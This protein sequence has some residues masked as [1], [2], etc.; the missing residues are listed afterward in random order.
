MSWVN[1]PLAGLLLLV[2]GLAMMGGGAWIGVDNLRFLEADPEIPSILG[3]LAELRRP[4]GQRPAHG[5]DAIALLRN[6]IAHGFTPK[7][8]GRPNEPE[9][10]GVISD[11]YRLAS[12][13]AALGILW[14][15][16]YSG[17]IGPLTDRDGSGR[18][19]WAH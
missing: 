13:Y 2:G 3:Q 14:L 9:R 19:P 4:D 11:A 12:R 15:S 18:V 1:H 8:R 7:K 16:R 17:E 10:G 5:P 6:R